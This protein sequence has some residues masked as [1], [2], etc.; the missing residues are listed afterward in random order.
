M[1]VQHPFV[2][3]PLSRTLAVDLLDRASNPDHSAFPDLEDEDPEPEVSP[4][5]MG[6][7]AR[8]PGVRWG[9]TDSLRGRGWGD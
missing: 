3:Q 9:G 2:S 4:V 7:G 6:G 5:A 1:A 8:G